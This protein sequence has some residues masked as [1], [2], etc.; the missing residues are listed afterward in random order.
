[1]GRVR[2]SSYGVVLAGL[3]MLTMLIGGTAVV[4]VNL[5]ARKSTTALAE[6]AAPASLL[7]LNLDRDA[8]QAQLYLERVVVLEAAGADSVSERVFLAQNLGQL[9]GPRWIEFREL[10]KELGHRLPE[11]AIHADMFEAD[12][13]IWMATVDRVIETEPGPQR[14]R[15]LHDA[16]VEFETM[17]DHL[18]VLEEEHYE[19][20]IESLGR[21]AVHGLDL[22]ATITTLAVLTSLALTA[23]LAGNNIASLRRQAREHGSR[24]AVLVED[25]DRQ[26]FETKFRRALEMAQTE[27]TAI[28]VVA[29]AS[30]QRLVDTELNSLLIA[31]QPM[32]RLATAYQDSHGDAPGCGVNSPEDCRALV[33]GSQQNFTDST[34]LDA[35]PHLAERDD[36]QRSATCTPISIN[37]RAAGVL[38]TT[39]LTANRFTNDDETS[40][41]TIADHV[42][43]R[44]SV[45]RNEAL[46]SIQASTDPLTGLANRRSFE[47]EAQRLSSQSERLA[48]LMID[49]DRFKELNDTHGHEAGDRALRLFADAVRDVTTPE[50]SVSAR[51]G[52]E[53]FIIAAAGLDVDAGVRLAEQLRDALAV[54]LID[55]TSPAFTVSIGVA[56]LSASEEM[57]IATQS[58]DRALYEAKRAGRDRVRIAVD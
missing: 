48:V 21:D 54:R 29:K 41:A 16:A 28:L 39:R 45:L 31:D 56:S 4:T 53:E 35:C 20:L 43:I 57:S 19:P 9:T 6:R 1:M 26:Q 42:G 58:A 37:G 18:D 7:V 30:G 33:T 5:G 36:I 34:A 3:L 10:G 15:L 8:Y 25:A 11:E 50:T 46:A 49:L 38:H 24:E 22:N 2:N 14:D 32:S 51:W 23:L 13:E 44:L 12:R 17:R 40:L 27:E 52:G 55:G 47:V